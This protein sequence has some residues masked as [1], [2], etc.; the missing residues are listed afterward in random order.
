MENIKAVIFDFGGVL[1]DWNPYYLF[2]KVMVN[3][4]EI[5]RFLQEI[6]FK[7]WNYEFDKGYPFDKGVEDLCQKYPHYAELIRLFDER[8]METLGVPFD[9]TVDILNKVKATGMPVYGLTNWSVE[10]FDLVR[11]QH[12]FFDLFEDMVISGKE[13]IAKP[14]PRIYKLLLQ[15]NNLNANDCV[16][17]DDSEDNI[18]AGRKVGLKTIH[19]QS[20]RQLKEALGSFGVQLAN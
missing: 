2:R 12:Q 16:Y 9:A 14:D 18:R 6:D 1:I 3:D 13:K 11:P 17:I 8:W 15:R 19:Y 4:T 10:K 7:T 5:E 20:S